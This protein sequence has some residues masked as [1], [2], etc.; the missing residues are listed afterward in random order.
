[1]DFGGAL[2]RT[3]DAG[4]ETRSDE[5]PSSDLDPDPDSNIDPG[6][7]ADSAS[8]ADA[9]GDP[10]ADTDLETAS[11]A[12]AA[13]AFFITNGCRPCG[14]FGRMP[15]SPAGFTTTGDEGRRILTA[16]SCV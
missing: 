12:G 4:W 2:E 7:P 14:V 13:G 5:N 10:D 11:R 6:C 1:M 15:L 16:S 9:D 3:A 8:G